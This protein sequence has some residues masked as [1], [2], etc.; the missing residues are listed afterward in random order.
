MKNVFLA[1]CLTAF[2]QTGFSQAVLNYKTK[3]AANE[4]ER[5]LMLDIY[6]AS[7]YKEYKQEFV[8][9]VNHFKVSGNYA[10]MMADVQRKDGKQVKLPDDGYDCCHVEALFRKSGNKWL[11]ADSGAF[12][13]DVWYVDLRNKYRDLPAT[14]FPSY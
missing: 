14:I 5:T 8:F 9:I 1:L 6:R 3:N 11:L 12:S 13:T 2:L 4:K 10:W 7:L